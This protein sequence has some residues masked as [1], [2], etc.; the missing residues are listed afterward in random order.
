M[1]QNIFALFYFWRN[2]FIVICVLKSTKVDQEGKGIAQGE[3]SQRMDGRIDVCIIPR[4]METGNPDIIG[5]QSLF[6]GYFG[7]PFYFGGAP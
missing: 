7:G 5:S 6:W 1:C 2:F 3:V 4:W